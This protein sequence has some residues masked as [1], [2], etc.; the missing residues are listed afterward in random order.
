LSL[1]FSRGSNCLRTKEDEWKAFFPT[2]GEWRE[3]VTFELSSERKGG[4]LSAVRD[5]MS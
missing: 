2:S 1:T 5:Y 4:F 3:V